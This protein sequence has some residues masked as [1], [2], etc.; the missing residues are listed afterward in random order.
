MEFRNSATAG[1]GAKKAELE[2]KGELNASISAV[3]YDYLAK[4]RDRNAPYKNDRR[5]A[6]PCKED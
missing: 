4:K 5:H 2:G 1:N 3:I 6:R